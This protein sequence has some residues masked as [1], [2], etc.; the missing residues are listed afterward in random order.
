[1]SIRDRKLLYHITEL[2]NLENIINHGLLSRE[3][4]ISQ[5]I[6][7]DNVVD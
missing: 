3:E 4:L 5:G 2:N 7:F 6:K 1:M